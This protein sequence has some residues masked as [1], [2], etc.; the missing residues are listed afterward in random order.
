MYFCSWGSLSK[1]TGVICYF[2][3]QEII[4][5]HHRLIGHECEQILGDVEGQGTWG[6]AVHRA[7]KIWT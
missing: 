2:L 6:A 3:L 1:D 5:Q 7:V 4:K